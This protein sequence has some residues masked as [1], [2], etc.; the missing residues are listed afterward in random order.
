MKNRFVTLMLIIMICPSTMF[1]QEVKTSKELSLFEFLEQARS[2]DPQVESV[3][4]QTMQVNFLKKTIMPDQSLVFQVSNQYGFG[5][6]DTRKTE[7]WEFSA[8]QPIVSS[9]TN[10]VASHRI[11][12][13]VDRK[14]KVSSISLEQSLY[15]NAFGKRDRNLSKRL[16]IENEVLLLQT[17]EA[18]ED[19][20]AVLATSYLNWNLLHLQ[21]TATLALKNE[22]EKLLASIQR[23]QRMGTALAIDVE[24]IELEKLGFE[25]NELT[26]NK[27]IIQ[28]RQSIEQAILMEPGSKI[29]PGPLP[30][31]LLAMDGHE[32]E[33][34]FLR[35]HSR[36]RKALT[37]SQEAG[38]LNVVVKESDMRPDLNAILGFSYDDSTRFTT[39]TDRQQLFVGFNLSVPLGN[40]KK[41]GQ[42]MQA[43]YQEIEASIAK[44]RFEKNLDIA[45]RNQLEQVKQAHMAVE[46][47]LKKWNLSTA[48]EGKERKRY[49]QGRIDVQTLI[50]ARQAQSQH[51]F[52]YLSLQIELAKTMIEWL[53]VTDQLVASQD[54]ILL[55]EKN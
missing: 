48:I 28:E 21:H 40:Q 8:T 27:Q 30:K 55:H 33:Y 26:L 1:S 3:L 23:R 46:V 43:S 39:S 47:G 49:E 22:S 36:T 2:H 16:D 25:E 38:Q 34:A 13:Q 20:I 18:Y 5:I 42:T 6:D 4:Q 14:E 11:N 44:R 50:N 19:Y 52:S 51:Q 10:V 12:K 53:R 45:Y 41:K 17:A 54:Q 31:T 9:G 7:T 29:V 15:R 24:K 35:E 37:L 32:M